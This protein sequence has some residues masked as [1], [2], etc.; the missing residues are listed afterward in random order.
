MPLSMEELAAS[1]EA[2][3][4]NYCGNVSE[5][6]NFMMV[7]G[8]D[9]LVSKASPDRKPLIEYIAWGARRL[10]EIVN[11]KSLLTEEN[12][13]K[14]QNDLVQL[15]VDLQQV[16]GLSQN[17]KIQTREHGEITGC[18]NTMGSLSRSGRII[19]D[20]L[21]KDSAL[22][23]KSDRGCIENYINTL[24]KAQ[25][26]DLL[27]KEVARLTMEK[28]ELT[29][30]VASL[31][32]ENTALS[33]QLASLGEKIDRL[34]DENDSSSQSQQQAKDTKLIIPPEISHDKVTQ[35]PKSYPNTMFK[36]VRVQVKS[37]IQPGSSSSVKKGQE[38]VFSD[39]ALDQPS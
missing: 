6:D 29:G 16:S 33:G 12:S 21:F 19:V 17:Q 11:G 9:E 30:Q 8:M 18:L 7:P 15:L 28:T 39:F 24:F 26:H 25:Q 22:T 36:K 5:A 4:I 35:S 27:R 3:I 32:G 13:G 37:R 23:L 1:L 2:I 10:H 31:A 20:V 38:S 14:V 34:C